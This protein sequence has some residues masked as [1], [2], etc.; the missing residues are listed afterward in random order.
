MQFSKCSFQGV[1]KCPVLGGFVHCCCFLLHKAAGE[2]GRQNKWQ[3]CPLG[4]FPISKKLLRLICPW[5]ETAVLE[6]RIASLMVLKEQQGCENNTGCS[7]S[8]ITALCLLQSPIPGSCTHLP[9][10]GPH[11][12]SLSLSLWLRGSFRTSCDSA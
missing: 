6:E 5:D 2:K 7:W 8:S 12:R 4:E 10:L 11:L 3:L 9:G 1:N